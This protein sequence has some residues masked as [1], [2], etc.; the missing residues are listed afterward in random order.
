MD[1]A[2]NQNST[3]VRYTLGQA[4]LSAV[5]TQSADLPQLQPV[6][7]ADGARI[8]VAIPAYNEDRFIGSLVL[9]L[10]GDNKSVLVVDDGSADATA[11]VAEAAGARVV[12]HQ[13]NKGKTAAVETIFREARQMNADVL[14]LLDGD[15]QHDPSEV[16][17]LAEPI[18]NGEA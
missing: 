8:V 5:S 7:A 4:K 13:I 16:D 3:D 10:R 1:A 11:S 17:L 9:K 6:P 14:V 18:L 2:L 12:R 15:S